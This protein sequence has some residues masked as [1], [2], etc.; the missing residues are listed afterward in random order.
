VA[1]RTGAERFLAPFAKSASAGVAL[2]LALAALFACGCGGGSSDPGSESTASSSAAA[3]TGQGS[4]AVD[5]QGAAQG[6]A[7]AGGGSGGESA[8]QSAA[9][10]VPGTASV[11]AGKGAKHG[12]RIAQPT[13]EP[14]QAPSPAQVAAATV[15]DMSLE[16][17]AI[18]ASSEGPGAIPAPYTCDGKDSWPAFHWSGVPAGT[19][20]LALFVMNVQPVQEKLF[21]DWAVAGLD[22]SLGGIEAGRLPKGAVVGTNG[23]GKADYEICPPP[24]SG[25]IY[26]FAVYAL[27]R[28]LLPPKGFEAR[29]LRAQ[30]LATSG[31]V[32]LLPAA[33]ARG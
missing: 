22:P 31:N 1:Q 3:G 8:A 24:N 27:P 18:V 19:A 12:Q 4:A 33:Y 11:P 14:E 20:E 28:R 25:E 16:S 10:A 13:G 26:M 29:E 32:G 21:V 17:P 15:A 6:T 2:A 7:Q 23:F 30:V 9:A 5:S